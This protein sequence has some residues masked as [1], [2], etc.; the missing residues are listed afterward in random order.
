VHVLASA[1]AELLHAALATGQ[2]YKLRSGDTVQLGTEGSCVQVQ[3]QEVGQQA[4]A[5]AAVASPATK[6]CSHEYT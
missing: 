6:K 4:A 5:R 1:Q 2:A 3:F